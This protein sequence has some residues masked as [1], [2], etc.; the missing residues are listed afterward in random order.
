MSTLYGVNC[1]YCERK[2]YV[3]VPDTPSLASSGEMR[4]VH[5][6]TPCTAC[7][8]PVIAYTRST[9]EWGVRRKE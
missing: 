3:Q 2:A 6:E 9:A 4:E 8:K 1:P 5:E 7:G